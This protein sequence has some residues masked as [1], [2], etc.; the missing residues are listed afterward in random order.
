MSKM[1]KQIENLINIDD[2]EESLDDEF[3]IENNIRVENIMKEDSII[4][5]SVNTFSDIRSYLEKEGLVDELGINLSVDY[6]KDNMF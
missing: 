5:S 2:E 4:R 1:S 6:I 3:R